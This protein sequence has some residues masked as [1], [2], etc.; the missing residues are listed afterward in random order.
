MTLISRHCNV[1]SPVHST[2]EDY[3]YP[4]TEYRLKRTPDQ[5]TNAE[6]N[7][8]S[9]MTRT[10][11]LDQMLFCFEYICLMTEHLR[12]VWN[13]SVSTQRQIDATR[14]PTLQNVDCTVNTQVNIISLGYATQFLMHTE[15]QNYLLQTFRTESDDNVSFLEIQ[16][17]QIGP[18][19]HRV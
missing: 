2:A 5:L 16:I 3:I 9:L 14:Y 6:R 17:T 19:T 4:A 7:R 10:Q 18:A 11:W 1:I 13:P 8:K 15:F 12:C